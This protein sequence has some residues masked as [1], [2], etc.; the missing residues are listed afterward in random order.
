MLLSCGDVTVAWCC[1]WGQKS[2]L[3]HGGVLPSLK[4][5]YCCGKFFCVCCNAWRSICVLF[6]VGHIANWAQKFVGSRLWIFVRGRDFIHEKVFL[7]VVNSERF[8]QV[9]V[10]ERI[11]TVC[12]FA[13]LCEG[14]PFVS[15]SVSIVVVSYCWGIVYV[16]WFG[17]GYFVGC[18]VWY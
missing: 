13:Y 12:F 5:G 8:F 4:C 9:G 7:C 10:S 14:G 18:F 3:L 1:R 17:M 6:Y 15:G 2:E 16:V 11:G